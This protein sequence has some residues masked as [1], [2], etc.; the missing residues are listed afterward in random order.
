MAASVPWIGPPL[1]R[2]LRGGEDVTGATLTRFFGFHVAVLPGLTTLFLLVHLFWC[3]SS[4]SARLRGGGGSPAEV[5]E[6]AADG[7]SPTSSC[8][9]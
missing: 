5:A 7:S 4:A 8:A 6:R 1:A 2:F 9:N 3:R